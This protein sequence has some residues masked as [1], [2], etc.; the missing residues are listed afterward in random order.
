MLLGPGLGADKHTV[1]FVSA[2]LAGKTPTRK[3]IG[4]LPQPSANPDPR[5]ALPP[6]VVDADGLNA[7]AQW[8]GGPAALPPLSVLTPH[9]GEM[10]RLTGLSTGEINADRWQVCRRFAAEWNQVVVLK[11]AFTVIAQPDGQ[12][13]ISPF[14]DAALA[15]AGSGDVLA[16]T[17]V[18]LLSQGIGSWDAARIAVYL[19]GL[20]GRLAAETVG[21]ALLA[22][23]ISRH[24]PRALALLRDC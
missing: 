7:V 2:L 10:A 24:L 8:E 23:D 22:S 4:F 13:A 21:P 11:G 18:G 15:T 1:E 6:L 5:P 19:H 9:P 17:L 3:Q 20:A 14:A 12:L 16:G